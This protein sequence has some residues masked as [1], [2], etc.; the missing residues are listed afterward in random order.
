MK[1]ETIL[2]LVPKEKVS[3]PMFPNYKYKYPRLA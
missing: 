1:E 3:S 2:N